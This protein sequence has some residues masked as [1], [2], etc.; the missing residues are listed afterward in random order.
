[1][2]T[3]F[4]DQ[5]LQLAVHLRMSHRH[6]EAI[7]MLKEVIGADPSCAGAFYQLA[8]TQIVM[9]ERPK[10]VL[11]TIDRGI[12]IEPEDS[13]FHALR[14]QVLSD[15]SKS[16]EAH[17]AAD[18]ASRLDPDN[19]GAHLAKAHAYMGERRWAQA[20]EVLKS[21]LELDADNAAAGNLLAHV[22][23]M[24]NK[25]ADTASTI[26]Q[27]LGENPESP[28]AHFNA[29]WAALQKGDH[30]AANQ[31]FCEALRLDP[32]FDGARAGLLESFKARNPLY[33][34]YLSY[35]TFMQKFTGAT[36][37]IMIIGFYI[38]YRVIRG[39]VATVSPLAATGVMVVY[40]LFVLWV[41][42]A[43]GIGN[44]LILLDR[45]AKHALRRNECWEGI[46]VG[47]GL[48]LGLALVLTG[49]LTEAYGI[50][51]TGG[52]V[53]LSAMPGSLTFTNESSTGRWVFGSVFAAMWL[54]AIAA[55]VFA[56]LSAGVSAGPAQ[57]YFIG[58]VIASMLCTWAGN[59][60][61]LRERR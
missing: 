16:K 53:A 39:A 43:S 10:I 25:M 7:A 9:D 19:E 52:F 34:G 58:A 21:V 23:R 30:R 5:K 13:D 18:E 36:Q 40:L 45:Y 28:H 44:G 14:A 2:S 3:E 20:E 26:Q 47:G 29:G 32:S 4:T 61:A 60:E 33:R 11:E 50:A 59:V 35:C 46:F 42:L 57:G 37:W 17:A 15:M 55:A 24:Q 22:Q 51:F 6:Q 56:A 12:A 31:H 1:M 27:L 48:L 8:I 38:G 54:G 49:I 41:W